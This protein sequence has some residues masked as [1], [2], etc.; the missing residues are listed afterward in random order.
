MTDAVAVLFSRSRRIQALLDVEVAL[1][2]AL[3]EAGV[4]PASSV[5][6]IR[7]AARAGPYDLDA[8]DEDA[9]AAGNI[10][11]PLVRQL[12]ARVAALDAGAARHV[13]VGATSQDVMDTALVLQLREAVGGLMSLL[14]RSADA[15]AELARRHAG[16]PMAGRTWLQQA[17]P[18]TFG[19]KAAAWLDAIGSARRRLAAALDLALELQL[20]G[21][22]G[23]LA[24]LGSAG[25][26]VEQALAARLEL[27]VPDIPWHTERSRLVGV[28]S[29]LGITCGAL[30]KIARD[31]A[32]LAQ[33]EIDEVREPHVPGRG[34]SSAMPHKRNPVASAVSIAAAI[35]APGLVATMLSAM[36]QE[37]ERGLG[38][39]QA[40]WDTLPAL[41]VLTSHSAS[42]MAGV[43]PGLIVNEARMRCNLDAAGGVARA[44]G[45]VAA[46]A[47][48]LGWSEARMLVQRVCDAAMAGGGRLDEVAAEDPDIR[49]CLD[50]AEVAAALDPASF[51]G[52]ASAFV[53]R[54]LRRWQ[55]DRDQG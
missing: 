26:A 28:A 6:A 21:A 36:P 42:A 44:E 17:T 4:I 49:A 31:I 29:A 19:A 48:R 53:E 51:A 33:T 25:P 46:L 9:R 27:R 15:A 38:G 14:D 39:W 16:T 34:S 18:T 40:E 50:A 47:P 32:L 54:V 8:L 41:V 1:A 12:T 52:A 3:A 45:L 55:R 7:E 13:H 5:P 43:L 22:T 24:S 10:L 37:H 30:G 11:I 2:E 23:T 35:Q 20:G